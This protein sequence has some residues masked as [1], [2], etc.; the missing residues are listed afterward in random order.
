MKVLVIIPAYN[1]SENIVNTV[2]TLLSTCP[3]VDYVVVNDCSTDDTAFICEKKGFNYV[4]LPVNLGIGGSHADG[5]PLCKG[6][7]L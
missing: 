7:W 6:S 2:T 5:F 4:S 1:E 3:G